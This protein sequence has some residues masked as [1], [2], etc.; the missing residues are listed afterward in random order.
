MDL[1]AEKKKQINE[2]V[3]RGI[4]IP[5]YGEEDEKKKRCL[6]AEKLAS[7]KLLNDKLKSSTKSVDSSK[8]MVMTA[9][10]RKWIMLENAK[11]TSKNGGK[12][13]RGTFGS[14]GSKGL[15]VT[16]KPTGKPCQTV[17]DKTPRKQ[18]PTKATRKARLTTGGVKK[19][20]HYKPGM[21]ALRE[22]CISRNLRSYSLLCY[23]SR[24]WFVRSLKISVSHIMFLTYGSNLQRCLH[25]RRQRK[26]IWSGFS[27]TLTY[28]LFT[29]SGRP[30]CQRIWRW[31]E[32]CTEGM[33]QSGLDEKRGGVVTCIA[34]R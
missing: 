10:E 30:S 17:G 3:K 11:K 13:P 6:H 27:M 1:E 14:K 31:C 26:R 21:V 23:H 24:G 18:M 32:G 4:L 25:C 29:P 33:T 20:R 9:A 34:T 5:V 15:K 8:Q 22:M 7:Q 12:A 16:V 2:W 19:P 28:V